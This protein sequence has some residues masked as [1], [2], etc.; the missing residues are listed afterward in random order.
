MANRYFIID[1]DST[2]VTV[3]TL[4]LLAEISLKNHPEREN[5]LLQIKGITQL[6]MEGKI[7]FDDS[8]KRRV[9]LFNTNKEFIEQ[10]I[11]QLKKHVS[12]S[13]SRN[14][15]FLKKNKDQIY[16]ISGGFKE[17]IAPIV[18]A[19]GI[20]EDHILANTFLFDKQGAV[21]G[22][23]LKNPLSQKDGKVK[24]VNALKLKG[25]VLVVGDGYTDYEIKK[26]GA[27]NKF[28]AFVE[29][30]RR[31][32]IVGL[33]DRVINSFDELL[34]DLREER[35]LS[36]PK[37]KMKV[38]LLENIDASAV[39]AFKKQGYQVNTMNKAL[40]EKELIREIRDVSVLGIRSKT[41]ITR[42][43]LNHA[44]KLFA[45]G[46]FCIGTNQIDLTAC[47]EK[48][49]AV[50]NAPYS[51]TRSVVELVIAEIII[52]N[53]KVFDKSQRMH[54]GIWDKSSIG[55]H[56]IRGRVLGII[57][58]GNIGTQLGVLA[59]NLGMKVYFYDT[60][61]K[62]ALGNARK[63]SSLND[64]LKIADII[65]VHVDGRKNNANLIS[66]K[67]LKKMKNGVIFLNLSRGFVVNLDLLAK[68]IKQGKV[69]GAS[70]DV[71]PQEPHSNDE[72]F[73]SA[74]QNLPNVI[75]TPHIG[76]STEEAQK[77]IGE[78]V[79][80]RLISYIDSGSTTLSVN[81]PPL[82]LPK[83]KNAH[84][85]IH[86]HANQPGVLAKFNLVLANYKI[87]IE[88]QYLG[89]SNEI[90]YVITDVNRSYSSMV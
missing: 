15:D 53:R 1:F 78:F 52:L 77:N 10:L 26:V 62:P 19:F 89:T 20:K 24:A 83:L 29:N 28:Y 11:K 25:E 32:S 80:S 85:L 71:F 5:L 34:Y 23:D 60:S 3:E 44:K 90:G 17:Y 50:F 56:E 2:F 75:L 51:N 67:E 7:R 87:N 55:S 47:A 21:K 9:S 4:D 39:A 84:R 30:V 49:I 12:P 37:S 36:Y 79:S 31:G 16:I 74:L 48:G 69:H 82:E 42:N 81:F 33:A 72:K 46:A 8:L 54:Q 22:F 64:L 70:I 40:N 76:G 61:E 41:E 35:V 6:G 27:A 68:Y 18:T 43:M 13:V 58:Y 88:G 38:L 65:T 57:G 86:I 45:V 66:D 73:K 63:C 59:E 14:K